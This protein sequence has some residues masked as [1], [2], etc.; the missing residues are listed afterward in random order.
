MIDNLSSESKDKF[1]VKCPSQLLYSDCDFRVSEDKT[2]VTIRYQIK[3]K[4]YFQKFTITKKGNDVYLLKKLTSS[5]NILEYKS[6]GKYKFQNDFHIGILRSESKNHAIVFFK[7]ERKNSKGLYIR[8][9][10]KIDAPSSN[11]DIDTDELSVNCKRKSVSVNES[12]KNNRVEISGESINMADN[13]DLTALFE[14][15]KSKSELVS[16]C[17]PSLNGC[18]ENS[19]FLLNEILKKSQV[20]PSIIKIYCPTTDKFCLRDDYNFHYALII[21]DKDS[22]KDNIID[23]TFGLKLISLEEWINHFNS[24]H[25]AKLCLFYLYP[26]NS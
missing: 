25:N 17:T 13:N 19:L 8:I 16:T 23:I 11:E 10:S 4:P 21:R 1:E 24:K 2:S 5:I 14:Y 7:K 9:S 15:L 18:Y 22:E 26:Q 3:N 20:N 6:R 12:L